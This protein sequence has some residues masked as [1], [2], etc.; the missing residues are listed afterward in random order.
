[1]SNKL[2]KIPP[3]VTE[4]IADS[5]ELLQKSRYSSQDRLPEEA[6]QP[7]PSL[8][9]RCR[10]HLSEAG[11][12]P[13]RV[14]HHLACT[15]GTL[16]T[17]CLA[18][19]P[20]VLVLN[21]LDPLSTKTTAAGLFTPTDLIG[22]LANSNRPASMEDKI[23]LFLAGFSSLHESSEQRGLRMLVRDHAHSHFCTG[24]ALPQR[25][26][27]G[28][29]F[30]KKFTTLAVVTVRHPL[31]S[32]LSLVHNGWVEFNP[33]TL[34]EYAK[35]YR[36]FLDAHGDKK[37]FKY[38]DFVDSPDQTLAA[39]CSELLLPFAPGFKDLFM[40]HKLSG[41]SGRS[42]GTIG[43]RERRPLDDAIRSEVE[44]SESF[45]ALCEDLGYAL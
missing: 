31:D 42:S 30:K 39:I 11:E 43:Q 24:D 5:L 34:D 12:E 17:K 40:V 41:D 36:A 2:Q 35:R 25:P 3:E 22:L 23:G 10:R 29:I 33:G 26:T 44:N 15:G 7:L 8:L 38:E 6:T 37:V 16:I 18:C 32:W 45:R 28:E 13:V 9:E 1:M 21:E 4:A 27:L 20:N 14:I 19:S